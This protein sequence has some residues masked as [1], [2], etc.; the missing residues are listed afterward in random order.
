MYWGCEMKCRRWMKGFAYF[1][2]F[3]QLTFLPI[4]IFVFID[5]YNGKFDGSKY[6][7]PFNAV[8]PFNKESVS[9]WLLTWF[10]QLNQS[11][12]YSGQMLTITI[13]FVCF[14]YYIMTMCN[15]FNLLIDSIR[16][17]TQQ[18]QAKNNTQIR[19]QIW[20]NARAKFQ[21]AIEL[22]VDIYE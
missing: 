16:F 8:V 13:H 22:H 14:C 17:D 21:Q 7:L 12:A 18:I 6:N 3:H 11:F 19:H 10:Y 4:L 1:G 2:C 15:H 9:G 5:I 20:M